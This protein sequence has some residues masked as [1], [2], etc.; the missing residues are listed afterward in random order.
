[1]PSLHQLYDA[2]EAGTLTSGEKEDFLHRL[3]LPEHT[4]EAHDII[5]RMA[6]KADDEGLAMPPDRLALLRDSIV[7]ADP[8]KNQPSTP[9]R[10][11]RTWGWAAAAAVLVAA[12]GVYYWNRPTAPSTITQGKT[13]IQPGR[14]GAILTLDDG[15][16]VV[17]DSLGNGL[18][19]TQNGARV[20]LR[21]G[22]LD[23]D[24]ASESAPE[25]TF[26]TMRTPRGRQFQV[27]LPDGTQVWLN[28]ASSIRYPTAFGKTQRQVELSGEAYFDVAPSQNAPFIVKA[29]DRAA[30]EVLGT[31][32]NV[33]AY[34]DEKQLTATLLRG[35]VRVR[36]AD[37][38]GQAV[39][40]PGQQARIGNDA[41]LN[42]IRE[43]DTEKATA[44][45]AGQF[46][47][48]DT[49]LEE[50]MRQLERWYDV[51]T[52][53]EDDVKHLQFGSIISRKEHVESVLKLLEMTGEVSFRMEGRTIIVSKGNK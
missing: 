41:R 25:A 50:I 19:A 7:A 47:F 36:T 28:A 16:E 40:A 14:D 4:D 15:T 5:R 1:M 43:A 49:S 44:W 51:E 52:V 27:R 38:N 21:N 53:Y 2:F 29:G 17:L 46:N 30:I 26:N 10:A 12:A 23:Y 48:E 22:Q 45:K 6:E 39:L 42:V 13:D 9:L 20:S 8:I 34:A 18:V 37:G 11:L 33:N 31:Q 32:F 35:A 24:Q 3:T